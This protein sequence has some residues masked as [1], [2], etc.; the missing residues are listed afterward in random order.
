MGGLYGRYMKGCRFVLTFGS[1]VMRMHTKAT[2][3][4]EQG[5]VALG[6]HETCEKAQRT[7][8]V[9]CS[10]FTHTINTPFF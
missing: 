5:S 1:K 3:P 7:V 4:F 10:A 8:D 2:D 6:K 9:M